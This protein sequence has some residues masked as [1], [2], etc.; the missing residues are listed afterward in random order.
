MKS[1]WLA[2][3]LLASVTIAHAQFA[4]PFGVGTV[5]LKKPTAIPFSSQ[6]L[7]KTYIVSDFSG[8]TMTAGALTPVDSGGAVY[9]PGT[10]GDCW[11]EADQWVEFIGDGTSDNATAIC[12]SVDGQLIDSG[13]CYWA[14]E[15]NSGYYGSQLSTSQGTSVAVGKHTVQTIVTSINSGTIVSYGITYRVYK[16]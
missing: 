9:C 4:N 3:S 14:G 13:S 15:L 11:I 16:P 7:R 2:V 1:V 12:L 8:A 10:A 5:G 6:T